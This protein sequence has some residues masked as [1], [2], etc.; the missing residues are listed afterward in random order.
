MADYTYR[1]KTV[2]QHRFELTAP[3]NGAELNK[4][5][6]AAARE[7]RMA[8]GRPIQYD[9]DLTVS[10]EDETIVIWFEVEA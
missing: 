9:D 7:F 4:A 5:V 8:R 1:K 2:T 6:T 10:P 3:T